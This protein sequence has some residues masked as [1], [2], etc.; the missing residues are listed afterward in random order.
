VRLQ[1][2]VSDDGVTWSIGPLGGRYVSHGEIEW[3]GGAVPLFDA[4]RIRSDGAPVKRAWRSV[5]SIAETERDLRAM[6]EQRG[7][8]VTYFRSQAL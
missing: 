1:D 7:G 3:S 2:Y 8:R 6:I 5:N 4:W